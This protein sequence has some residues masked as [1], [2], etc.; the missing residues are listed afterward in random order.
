MK[1]L[2]I[3]DLA[4]R[5]SVADKWSWRW[6]WWWWWWWIW[7]AGGI[8][9]RGIKKYKEIIRAISLFPTRIANG[10]I[11]DRTA[12]PAVKSHWPAAWTGHSTFRPNWYTWLSDGIVGYFRHNNK[13]VW[14]TST[15]ED[16]A[17]SSDSNGRPYRLWSESQAE[18]FKRS[19]GR[20]SAVP[21]A[22]TKRT[23]RQD[24]KRRSTGEC[25]G[26]TSVRRMYWLH[27]HYRRD[28]R[29]PQGHLCNPEPREDRRRRPSGFTE[30]KD[31]T[32]ATGDDI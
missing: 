7:S 25:T 15:T 1:G 26:Y 22:C 8:S 6:R 28:G 3:C 30:E 2:E 24:I 21:V 9:D 31:I 20:N 10:Q 19:H 16:N 29:T 4:Y 12:T 32:E 13:T 18:H 17:Y 14:C 27:E 23:Q 11:S 5:A